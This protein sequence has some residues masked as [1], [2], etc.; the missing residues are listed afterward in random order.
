[1]TKENK[2]KLGEQLAMRDMDIQNFEVQRAIQW[3]TDNWDSRDRAAE[4]GLYPPRRAA[5]NRHASF[6]EFVSDDAQ[7]AAY[8]I[9]Q[10][11][12]E[13]RKAR[14]RARREDFPVGERIMI[15]DVKALVTTQSSDRVCLIVGKPHFDREFTVKKSVLYG[16]WKPC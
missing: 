13:L 14:D 9:Q 6:S 1:M 8:M 12:S 3:I 2:Y 11:K 10:W 4:Y 15:D 16:R 7:G 5:G